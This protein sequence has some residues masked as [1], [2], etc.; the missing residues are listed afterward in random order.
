MA[1]TKNQ[2]QEIVATLKERIKGVASIVFVNFHG[3]SVALAT[4]LRKK[5]RGQEVGLMVAKKTLIRRAFADEKITGEMPE[6]LGEVALAYGKDQL[7]PA[8]SVYEFEKANKDLVKILGGV[9]EGKYVNAAM[10]TEIASIPGREVLYGKLVNI[11][12]SPIQ[13][14]VM[15]LNEVSKLKTN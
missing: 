13:R 3:L 6:L 4:E 8:R 12:N 5:L 7:L 2:K 14:F 15:A 10:M 1:I 9:F 11:L